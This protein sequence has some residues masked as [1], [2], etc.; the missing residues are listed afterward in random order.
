[1]KYLQR[2]LALVAI[3]AGIFSCQKEYSIENPVGGSNAASQWEFKEGGVQFKGP[4][5]TAAIDTIGTYKFLT[6]TGRSEDGSSQISLQ[7]FGADL[8]VGTYKTPFSLFTYVKGTTSVYQTDQ[9]LADSFSIIITKLDTTGVSGTFSGKALSG[10]TGKTIVDGKFTAVFKNSP[11]VVPPPASK[12]SGQVMLWSKAGCGGGTSINPIAVTIGGTRTGSITKFFTT[13]PTTCDPVG[14]F[15]IKLPVGTYP[16][17]AKCGTDSVTGT[18]TVTKAGCTK[19]QVDFTVPIVTGDYFPMTKNSNWSYLYE[20]A[21]AADSLYT[22]STGTTKLLSG[23]TYNLFTNTDGV[24]KDS[25]YYRKSGNSY[26]QYSAASTTVDSGITITSPAFEYAFLVDNLAQNATF[27]GGPYNGSASIVGNPITIPIVL[28]IK[29]TILATGAT[30]TVGAKS[31]S[32][33]IKVK[34]VYS[35]KIGTSPATENYASEQWFS[36]GIGLIKY[37][38]YTD[39]PLFTTPDYILNSTGRFQVY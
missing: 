36:K 18:V 37:I 2:L 38:D 27:S 9:T 10:N 28:T 15:S 13:E 6:I 20:G 17:V 29:S 35:T 19:A 32:N 8:K 4:V 26:Y 5:D 12:D 1:M 24:V 25:S 7:V 11:I 21:T 30:V 23:N 14:S 39:A 31:Y 16:W 22:F 34:N 3:S 33:V